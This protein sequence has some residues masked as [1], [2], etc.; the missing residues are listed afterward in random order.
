MLFSIP[1]EAWPSTRICV[2]IIYMSENT[3]DKLNISRRLE[4]LAEMAPAVDTVCDI[5]AGP[6]SYTHLDV[7]KR[8]IL[9][10]LISMTG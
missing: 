2:K 1:A 9:R 7:Y 5:G 8:Q 6:V 3:S 4:L 10:I